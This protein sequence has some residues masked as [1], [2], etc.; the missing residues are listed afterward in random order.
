MKKVLGVVGV[1]LIGGAAFI[2]SGSYNVAATD[3]HWDITTKLL[4]LVRD[5]SV[6][7]AS[8]NIIV[9]ELND[10]EM[11]SNGAKNYDA[12]CVQCHL[13]PGAPKTEL[14]QALYPKPPTFHKN[15]D[16]H[17]HSPAETF[18][19]IKNG[20]KMTGMPAWGEFHTEQQ[21]WEMTAF[22]QELKGMS[23]DRYFELVGEGGHSHK[24]SSHDDTKN[25]GH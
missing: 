3:E 2:F 23:A 11:I 1:S 9:P 16:K 17:K 20:F 7:S 22:L 19:A 12:M 14:N 18:W 6:H 5:R 25:R 8:E 10:I 15:D 24:E 4:E 21:L 13:A